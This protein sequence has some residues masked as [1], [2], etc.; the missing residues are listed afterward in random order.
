MLINKQNFQKNSLKLFT[1][2]SQDISELRLKTKS[3]FINYIA[4][5]FNDLL[6]KSQSLL[7]VSSHE[8][9]DSTISFNS[10]LHYTSLPYYP[11][12]LLYR[13][14]SPMTVNNFTKFI[15]TLYFGAIDSLLLFTYN[16]FKSPSEKTINLTDISIV[17]KHF[18]LHSSLTPSSF[19]S[20]DTICKKF[21]ESINNKTEM[22]YDE[23]KNISLNVNCDIFIIVFVFICYYGGK[24]LSEENISF[25]NRVKKPASS[26]MSLPNIKW[27][28]SSLSTKSTGIS[29]NQIMNVDISKE[30]FNYIKK[31]I[32]LIS[33]YTDIENDDLSE[34]SYDSDMDTLN[35]FEN[36][37]NTMLSNLFKEYH[38]LAVSPKKNFDTILP[39]NN[40]EDTI[41]ANVNFKIT[42]TMMLQGEQ[43]TVLKGLNKKAAEIF[44]CDCLTSY[45][46]K[47]IRAKAYFVS[48]EI[49]L[50]TNEKKLLGVIQL[51]PNISNYYSNQYI[52]H[53]K[54]NEKVK[55]TKYVRIRI[56][57]AYDLY[58]NDRNKAKEI[59]RFIS[60]RIGL[61][62]CSDDISEGVI[63][64]EG[65]SNLINGKY[66]ID[67][68]PLMSLGKKI[69]IY[70][71]KDVI[72]SI[73]FNKTSA[74][75]IKCFSKN[76]ADISRVHFLFNMMKKISFILSKED[77]SF[78]DL[79]KP[80]DK[81]DNGTQL[82]LIYEVSND[83]NDDFRYK[84]KCIQSIVKIFLM[85]SSLGIVINI[86]DIGGPYDDYNELIM[87]NF[88]NAN[89]IKL[90]LSKETIDHNKKFGYCSS[91]VLKGEK[92][93]SQID[94]WYI[95]NVM[96]Y[97]IYGKLPF[98]ESGKYDNAKIYHSVINNKVS[99]SNEE[100]SKLNEVIKK[101]LDSDYKKRPSWEE[102][103]NIVD[104]SLN[105]IKY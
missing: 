15:N 63:E 65:Q 85:M 97:I 40:I 102:I 84:L 62:K 49:Y 47:L 20:I 33:D 70:K 56:Y 93:N 91:E 9:Y 32:E 24:M 74:T 50:L 57:N 95:G 10:F 31:E 11:C 44:K 34:D 30:G 104:D 17:L 103:L 53:R 82:H 12:Q 27:E 37:K 68:S 61:S 25:F 87:K 36:D 6:T 90:I 101:C 72:T 52:L 54:D 77:N 26:D 55:D 2:L 59:I 41:I 94:K 14:L 38:G 4:F 88:F 81:Y 105:D 96:Y 8:N 78:V 71:A 75:Y 48:N 23:W 100:Y 66:I 35:A 67:K 43:T 89:D 3:Y 1:H 64:E 99:F 51:N 29:A 58:I 13:S 60:R 16:I 69:K 18:H 5:I 86:E 83:D 22:T 45:N 19:E 21:K 46:K 76:E 92:S 98:C 80:I 73:Q 42:Q 79:I 28:S 7:T 39:S